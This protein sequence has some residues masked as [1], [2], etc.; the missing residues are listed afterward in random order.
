[1]HPIF[2][3]TRSTEGPLSQSD[4][5]TSAHFDPLAME[6]VALIRRQDPAWTGFNAHD[7]GVTLLEVGAWIT[8]RL[9][10]TAARS[11]PYRNFNFRVTVEGVPVAGVTKVSALR[12]STEVVEYRA[13]AEPNVVHRLPGR[14]TYAPFT[15]ER[16]LGS[17]PA[18][19]DWADLV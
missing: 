19:E 5:Q 6:L 3:S 15:L 7:P 16:P 12:R 4:S 10:G 1:M 11:D 18:F 2:S 13:G 14:L 8:E 17:D 9:G